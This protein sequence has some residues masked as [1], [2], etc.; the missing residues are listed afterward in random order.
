[1]PRRRCRAYHTYSPAA[2][3]NRGFE[4]CETDLVFFC[5]ADC[6]GSSD[7]FAKMA[8]IATSLKMRTIID[9]P[10]VLPVYHLNQADTQVFF[11]VEDMTCRSRFLDAMAFYS[12]LAEF[13]KEDNFFIAPYSNIFLI[14]RRMFSLTGGYDERFRGHGS[15]DFEFL[16]RLGLY[17]KNLPM[18]VELTKDH[19]GP[20][21][22]GF[23]SSRPYSGFRRFLE[24]L[25][26]PAENLGLRVF[27]LYHE[28]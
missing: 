11:D 27:H 1:M 18:P 26:K 12:P 17:I 16:T 22:E 25:S 8:S 9:T 14:N 20:L 3:H 10:L 2:A 28:R 24:A 6:F 19:L 13:R 4:K 21:R 7:M 15:E 23:F 5:D